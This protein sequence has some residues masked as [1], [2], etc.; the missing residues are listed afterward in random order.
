M[1]AILLISSTAQQVHFYMG[2]CANIYLHVCFHSVRCVFGST[3][4][5]IVNLMCCC[6]CYCGH[7]PKAQYIRSSTIALPK[8]FSRVTPYLMEVLASGGK[9]RWSVSRSFVSNSFLRRCTC[10]HPT[11][12]ATFPHCSTHCRRTALTISTFHQIARSLSCSP[13]AYRP[14]P[15]S[16]SAPQ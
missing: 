14:S 10:T 5:G 2:H 11:C 8:I 7:G 15:P 16:S 12:S 6:C 3:R 1:A 4:F 9:F 13:Y